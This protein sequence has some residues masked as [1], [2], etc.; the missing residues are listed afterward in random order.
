MR[1]Q[2]LAFALLFCLSLS[3]AFAQSSPVRFA[4]KIDRKFLH[5]GFEGM[6]VPWKCSVG[7]NGSSEHLPAEMDLKVTINRLGS[8]GI[9]PD[10]FKTN[11][12]LGNLISGLF[13][14]KPSLPKI[15]YSD[16]VQSFLQNLQKA[17]TDYRTASCEEALASNPVCRSTDERLMDKAQRKVSKSAFVKEFFKAED[18]P[19]V[20]NQDQQISVPI[21]P[22]STVSQL[23]E[24][25][26]VLARANW[27]GAAGVSVGICP[28][29]A[30]PGTLKLSSCPQAISRTPPRSLQVLL[31]ILEENNIRLASPVTDTSNIEKFLVEFYKMPASL[32]EPLKRIK[33]HLIEGNSIMDDEISR[34]TSQMSKLQETNRTRNDLPGSGGNFSNATRIVINHLYDNHGSK[35]LFL[36]EH[37]H[38]LDTVLGNPSKKARWQRIFKNPKYAEYFKILSSKDYCVKHADEAFTESLAYYSACPATREHMKAAV[39]E[40]AQYFEDLIANPGK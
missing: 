19:V 34:P 27:E 38:A 18:E 6:S 11:S 17:I 26:Q 40:I 7:K 37:G 3:S 22:R 30:K 36:H 23:E 28:E 24:A 20:A 10:I 14:K 31:P 12:T 16:C 15:D 2:T 39:P 33:I 35:N 25:A 4:Q 1:I 13:K 9:K 29:D 8:L 32:R 21:P 5:G